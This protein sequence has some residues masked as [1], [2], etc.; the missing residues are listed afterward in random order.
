MKKSTFL[1]CLA[2]LFSLTAHAQDWQQLGETIQANDAYLQ[3]GYSIT[4]SADGTTFAV[5]APDT[6]GSG[7]TIE[8]HSYVNV[9]TWQS[10]V[11]AQVGDTIWG[12]EPFLS[13]PNSNYFVP[14]GGNDILLSEDGTTIVIAERGYYYINPQNEN[15]IIFS[16]RVRIF[17]LTDG[18]WVQAGEDIF[19]PGVRNINLSH[20]GNILAIGDD[21]NDTN[22]DN[23]GSVKVFEKQDGEWV[24][25]GSTLYG[26]GDLNYFGSS[27]AL[28]ADG[29]VLVIG[30]S[31]GAAGGI[32]PNPGYTNVYNLENGEWVLDET[33]A[34]LY[35]DYWGSG[36][37]CGSSVAVSHDG[38]VVAMGSYQYVNEGTTT[39]V[40]NV[41]VFQKTEG[42]WQQVG[43]SLEGSR[44]SYENTKHMIDLS[45]DGSILAIGTRSSS[46][47]GNVKVYQLTEGEWVQAGE[48]ISSAATGESN[49]G[50]A[51][52]LSS[53]GS[54]VA[55]GISGA[56]VGDFLSAGAAKVYQNCSLTQITTEAEDGQTACNGSTGILTA[57]AGPELYANASLNWYDSADATEPVF[58]GATF[59]T[60]ELTADTTYW[61]EAETATGCSSARVEVTV[62]VNAVPDAPATEAEQE[63]EEGATLNS[64]VI[65]TTGTVVWYSDEALTTEI[66]A[67][68]LLADGTTYY[69]VQL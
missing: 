6:Q 69:A 12:G 50:T 33:F 64:L 56:N 7:G 4:L 47:L 44:S 68:T 34:G 48:T 53:D 5:G 46:M 43:G 3:L 28:S 32:T 14:G 40:G 37:G 62:T 57:T 27:V 1:F 61:V 39:P 10:G 67:G 26:T 21:Y 16:D 18:E 38:T 60:P 31:R 15:E 66:P 13:P 65:E 55:V 42:T 59:T 45:A 35:T 29:G 49:F 2:G 20:D 11:W 17:D 24:Q 41:R 23:S 63:F 8:D 30:C 19:E 52:S 22:G 51:L 54:I 9:Y 36:A 58:T 25:L